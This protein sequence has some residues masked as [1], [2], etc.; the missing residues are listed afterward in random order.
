MSQEPF[1]DIPLF[2]ELQRLLASSGEGPINLEIARQVAVAT[3]N[4]EG[5]D[6]PVSAELG[7]LFADSIH[8]SEVVLAGYTRLTVEEPAQGEMV[9]RS[10]WATRTL[11]EWRWL[12]EHLAER[13]GTAVAPGPEDTTQ[14]HMQTALKQITPLL[15]GIQAGTLIG[16]LAAEALTGY[17]P[18]I[19]RDG[20]SRLMAVATNVQHVCADY[21]LDVPALIRWLAMR[22]V[23]RHLVATAVPWVG[24]YHR[25]LLT[26]LVESIEID[27]DELERRMNELQT[28]GMEALQGAADGDQVL[29][30]V[31]SERHQRALQRVRAFTGLVEGYAVHSTDAVGHETLE[32]T[33]KIEEAMARHRASQTRGKDL[34]AALLGFSIDREL[35]ASGVTFC[36]AV[37]KLEGLLALNR[38]WDA[39]DNVPSYDELRDPFLWIERVVTQE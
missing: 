35:E 24:R 11:M 34:L 20:E 8:T 27:T 22:D 4:Q 26:E 18:P 30:V 33:K 31:P 19:P 23:A 29:P 6:A 9:G 21:D 5:S 32:D 36:A 25:S 37:V 3:A 39:P 38:V 17:D 1:G 16:S 13:F 12:L 14:E 10:G 15:L 28:L 7:N 2:R